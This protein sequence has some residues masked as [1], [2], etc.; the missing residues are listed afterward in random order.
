[1]LLEYSKRSQI[2]RFIC[3]STD[4]IYGDFPEISTESSKIFPSNPYSGSKA[5][6]EMI[7]LGYMHSFKLPVIITR[8]NNVYGQK[9]FPEKCIPRFILRLLNGQKCQI[10]GSGSQRRSF[11]HVDDVSSAFETILFNGVCNNIYNLEQQKN[12]QFLM[13]LND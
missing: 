10:Q 11:M 13:L 1:M 6:A 7:V 5:A 12:T 4:E 3:V 2:K 8:G 9:Q